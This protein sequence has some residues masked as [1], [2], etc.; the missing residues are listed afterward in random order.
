[1]NISRAA[2]CV[3]ILLSIVFTACTR[4]VVVATPR[5]TPPGLSDT[6]G[7]PPGQLPRPGECRIW[8]PG[9][10]PGQ[11]PRPERCGPRLRVPLGGWLLSRERDPEYV[12]VSVYDSAQPDIV[13]VI[14]VY[15]VSTGRFVR[16]EPR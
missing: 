12:R 11:Q 6:L 5:R 14:R 3:L 15:V 2:I 10:P 4:R 7:I 13:T 8:I 16:E 9:R 1:M